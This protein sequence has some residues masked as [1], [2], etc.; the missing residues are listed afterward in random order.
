M[1]RIGL[2]VVLACTLL[3][4]PL[5]GE[6]QQAGKVPRIGVISHESLPSE[7]DLQRSP[8]LQELRT[9]GWVEGQTIVI[10]R[11]YA[12]LNFEK[13]PELAADL[14]RLKVDVIVALGGPAAR[15]AKKATSTIPI[16]M[17][18]GNA[19]EQG[20]VTNLARP[21][22][23]R[24]HELNRARNQFKPERVEAPS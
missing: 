22:H 21:E 19:L 14:V 8:F 5:V 18:A 24:V 6:A 10:E 17:T 4:A 16:V 11:R 20:L 12:A 2:A 3:A 7:A 13:L 1:Q 23:H 9:R 15:A